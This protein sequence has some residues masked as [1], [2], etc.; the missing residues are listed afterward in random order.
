M[1]RE[2][3]SAGRHDD[4]TGIGES[5]F[6]LVAAARDAGLDPELE[7]RAAARR[8]GERVRGWE[9]AGRKGA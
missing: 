9:C 5:L 2:S 7:L 6:A 4:A 8:F 3:F 1:P